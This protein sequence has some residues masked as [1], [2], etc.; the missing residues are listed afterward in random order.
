MTTNCVHAATCVSISC[1]VS[2]PTLSSDPPCNHEQRLISDARCCA[3]V[4]M[5]SVFTCTTLC[6]LTS[7]IAS[8]LVQTSPYSLERRGTTVQTVRCWVRHKMHK[9]SCEPVANIGHYAMWHLK[10]VHPGLQAQVSAVLRIIKLVCLV[11][12]CR[13]LALWR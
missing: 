7:P 1:H 13:E 8:V 5:S 6:P 10:H 12:P 11:V 9:T 2:L 4:S 3:V